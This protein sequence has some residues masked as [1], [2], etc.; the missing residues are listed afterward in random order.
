MVDHCT[1][2]FPINLLGELVAVRLDLPKGVV[3]LP[4]WKR[5]LSGVV[6]AAGPDAYI[7]PGALVSFGA[8]VGMDSVFNGQPIR[9]LKEQDLDFVYEA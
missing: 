2:A 7:S 1:C 5:S 9:V 4:D 3:V 8:A 6:L